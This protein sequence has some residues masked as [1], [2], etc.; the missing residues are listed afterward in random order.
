MFDCQWQ[1]VWDHHPMQVFT[2]EMLVCL[3]KIKKMC[4]FVN[5]NPKRV[6]R[7]LLQP[8]RGCCRLSYIYIYYI[9]L[10]SYY[11]II[12][13]YY[14]ILYNIILYYYHIILLSYYIILYDIILYYNLY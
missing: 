4:T 14:I 11:I 9:I 8:F 12:I 13:L 1:V 5:S 6:G 10:L 7:R 3:T 2:H